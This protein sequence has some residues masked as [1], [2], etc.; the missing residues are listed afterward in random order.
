MTPWWLNMMG[1][2]LG[3]SH[4]IG[5]CGGFAA[6]IG[7]RAKSLA[8]NFRDQMVYSFGRI[9]SYATLGGVAGFAGKRIASTLP[10]VIN[11]PAL[12]CL[13]AGVF[14]IRE[15]LFA[16]GL[17]RRQLKGASTSGCLM[18]PLFSSILRQ[19]GLTNTFLAGAATGFLPCG[20]VYSFVSLAASSADLLQGMAT[21]AQ[22]GA[23]T[24]PLMVA[25]GCGTALLSWSARQWIWKVAGW[26]VLATG[27][28]T[29]GR[30]AAFLQWETQAKPAA[31]PFCQI[32]ATSAE[33]TSQGSPEP[34]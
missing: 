15:G 9:A 22:F 4:C 27:I 33:A 13:I 14:L 28:L 16:S 26:S 18:R 3:S 11:V 32:S 20:L 12:L 17:V 6:I 8:G 10:S 5:M 19:P 21:M 30:G 2:L 29:L 31:C 1:G 7:M 23:G 25:T 34:R 24:I